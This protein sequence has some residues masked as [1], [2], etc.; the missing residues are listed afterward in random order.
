VI[1]ND[2]RDQAVE[3]AEIEIHVSIPIKKPARVSA[4]GCSL[5]K[6]V[7]MPPIARRVDD[8][9]DGPTA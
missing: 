4:G 5:Q 2:G 3:F 7:R 1:L 8:G 6:F 9:G